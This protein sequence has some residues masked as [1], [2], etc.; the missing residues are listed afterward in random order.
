MPDLTEVE[1]LRARVR[2][3]EA[4]VAADRPYVIALERIAEGP[5]FSVKFRVGPRT[6][7]LHGEVSAKLL[8]GW[9]DQRLP[10]GLPR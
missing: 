4:H 9:L 2:E 3:L 6:D 7:E 1:K 8:I 10:G 5:H